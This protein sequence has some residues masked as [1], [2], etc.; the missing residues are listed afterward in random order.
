MEAG[1]MMTVGDKKAAG[2]G[3]RAAAVASEVETTQD[4]PRQKLESRDTPRRQ[5]ALQPAGRLFSP[6]GSLVWMM[7]LLAVGACIA[8]RFTRGWLWFG[9]IVTAAALLASYDALELWLAREECA[10][11]LLPPEKGLRGGEGQTMEVP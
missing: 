5:I 1:E 6:T 10:P 4:P 11:V 7:G 3:P 2:G 8:P 9:L